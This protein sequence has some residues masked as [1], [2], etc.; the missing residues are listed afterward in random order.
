MKKRLI[1]A[2]ML[3]LLLLKCYAFNNTYIDTIQ[4]KNLVL[5]VN[6]KLCQKYGVKENLILDSLM[7]DTIASNLG[8]NNFES[9]GTAYRI[10]IQKLV[11]QF[12]A[13]QNTNNGNGGEP[14]L[15]GLPCYFEYE[16]DVKDCAFSAALG[17]FDYVVPGVGTTS[18]IL[19]TV[20]CILLAQ[21][22]FNKCLKTTY[23]Y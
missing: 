16:K 17:V 8:F 12:Q 20:G 22:N 19:A 11:Q 4:P 9:F 5:I 3:V 2:L 23:G 21:Y 10:A 6:D 14:P 18:A 13:S 15:P 7:L 1:L